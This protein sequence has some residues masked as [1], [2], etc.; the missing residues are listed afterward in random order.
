MRSTLDELLGVLGELRM[1]VDSIGPA[2]SMLA[3]QEHSS[4]R[5]SRLIR[6]RLDYAAF[7][8]ALYS[9]FEGFVESLVWS[10]AEL[11]AS[12][13]RYADLPLKLQAANLKQ[14]AEI[15]GRRLGE[16]RYAGTG[17]AEIVANLHA[18]LSGSSAYKLNRH[19]VV[20]HDMNLRASAVYEI[21]GV[22]G[23]ENVS[24]R[25]RQSEAMLA[26]FEHSKGQAA[27]DSLLDV[28][29]LRMRDLV[30][31]R[32][33][34][35]HSGGNPS[36]ILAPEEM[37]I[38]I[39]FLEAYSRALFTV[40][41]GAYLERC[42][43]EARAALT[44]GKPLEGPYRKGTAVVVGRPP[45]R[46]F[47]GQALFGRRNGHVDRWGQVIE[48]RVDDVPVESLE[49]DSLCTEVG[50]RVDFKLAKG[51]ELFV[52]AERDEAVWG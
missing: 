13:V 36:E 3:R 7:V 35:T 40:V 24:A 37:Q 29:E 6:R 47:T 26:W 41:A 27:A 17:G 28:I 19:A 48:L 45:C 42:Y 23:I 25:V 9:A 33:Q 49:E 43:V 16:G 44:L 50:L 52:L 5:E 8:V 11:V 22:L 14:S 4:L 12:R 46:L 34:V 32:N 51:M 10:H 31:R 2:D 18:C 15:L 30:E 39:E 21:F 38:R 1:F 20:Y